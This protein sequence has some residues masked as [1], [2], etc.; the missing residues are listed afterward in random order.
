MSVLAQEPGDGPTNEKALKTYKRALDYLHKHDLRTAFE[1]FKK[2]D[3]E[4][5][6]HCFACQRVMIKYGM[7]LGEWKMAEQGAQEMVVGAKGERDVAL[8][9]YQLEVVFTSEGFQK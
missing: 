5:G 7:E 9:H 8:A 6:G 3:K 4:D 1:D 2:A